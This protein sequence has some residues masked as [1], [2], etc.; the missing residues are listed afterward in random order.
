MS[1]QAANLLATEGRYTPRSSRL[2]LVARTYV[3]IALRKCSEQPR[4]R[5][6]EERRSPNLDSRTV[7]TWTR[8]TQATTLLRKHAPF[9]S[10]SLF[11]GQK[12][13]QHAARAVDGHRRPDPRWTQA[14]PWRPRSGR[15]GAGGDLAKAPRYGAELL[16][17]AQ[18][19]HRRCRADLYPS[20]SL[21]GSIGPA[22]NA[23][24]AAQLLSTDSIFCGS[25]PVSGRS[26]LRR[27]RC[28]AP[29]GRAISRAARQVSRR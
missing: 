7:E 26:Q 18:C 11:A 4:T 29:P 9:P 22:G 15:R 3:V 20:F 23:G 25:A 16:A 28:R 14:I 17:A 6:Q 2:R 12:R 1:K 27:I 19:A 8:S 13:A 24:G 21:V 10:G 5:L